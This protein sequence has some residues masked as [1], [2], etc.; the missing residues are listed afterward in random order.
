MTDRA[1]N[2]WSAVSGLKRVHARPVPTCAA[3][4]TAAPTWADGGDAGV[5]LQALERA[6]AGAVAAGR[7]DAVARL[8][9]EAARL[10]EGRPAAAAGPHPWEQFQL[11]YT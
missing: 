7:Y 9:A 11:V 5:L 8:V 1:F 6:C 2:H 3:D 4:R 10:R